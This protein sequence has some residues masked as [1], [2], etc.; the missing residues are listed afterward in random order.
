MEKKFSVSKETCNKFLLLF[1][2]W[3]SACLELK[4]YIAR[5]EGAMSNIKTRIDWEIAEEKFEQV[6]K[7]LESKGINASKLQQMPEVASYRRFRQ[8]YDGSIGIK[9]WQHITKSS[10]NDNIYKRKTEQYCFKDSLAEFELWC[11][12]HYLD[13]KRLRKLFPNDGDFS[14]WENLYVGYQK[15][16]GTEVKGMIPRLEELLNQLRLLINKLESLP[17]TDKAKERQQKK[18]QQSQQK[19][20]TPEKKGLKLK[21]TDSTYTRDQQNKFQLILNRSKIWS[22]GFEIDLS[23]ISNLEKFQEKVEK[24]ERKQGIHRLADYNWIINFL[25]N[26]K[27]EAD[28]IKLIADTNIAIEERADICDIIRDLLT[29]KGSI[30]YIKSRKN[31]DVR[32]FYIDQLYNLEKYVKDNDPYFLKFKR[33]ER[34]QRLSDI[35]VNIEI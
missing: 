32:K 11:K 28:L 30:R 34:K 3:K 12:K 31:H 10:S 26:P 8:F 6:T 25:I 4:K 29:L 17:T 13:E 2:S 23:K 24:Y 15:S 33:S 7:E 14:I 35:S 9:P 20:A 27:I 1:G 22:V 5:L 16:D 18:Q 21:I 19:V